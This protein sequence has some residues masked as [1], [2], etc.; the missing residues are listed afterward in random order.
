MDIGP[1]SDMD[2]F[3]TQDPIS[4]RKNLISPNIMF[5]ST[6]VHFVDLDFGKW[7]E[8]KQRVFEVLMNPETIQRWDEVLGSF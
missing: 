5:D 3:D 8:E 1:L 4:I 2:Q 6:R 7:D